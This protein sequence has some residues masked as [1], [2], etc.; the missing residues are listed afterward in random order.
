MFF[1]FSGEVFYNFPS[2]ADWLASRL[3]RCLTQEIYV[4]VVST[5]LSL[6]GTGSGFYFQPLSEQTSKTLC[7]NRKGQWPAGET[8]FTTVCS[9]LIFPKTTFS[10]SGESVCKSSHRDYPTRSRN[11]FL[12]ATTISIKTTMQYALWSRFSDTWEFFLYYRDSW[13]FLLFRRWWL[14]ESW[15]LTMF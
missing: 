8:C 4:S 1:I 15:Y 9:G 13:E 12:K 5:G 2:H 14:A 7:K 11:I 6:Q 10:P 3:S